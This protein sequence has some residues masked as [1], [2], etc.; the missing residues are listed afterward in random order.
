MMRMVL[1]LWAFANPLE[2]ATAATV[3]IPDTK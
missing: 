2:A 3:A 1:L